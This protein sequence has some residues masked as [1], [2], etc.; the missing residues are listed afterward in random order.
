MLEGA[1]TLLS[2][3]YIVIYQGACAILILNLE[4][5]LGLGKINLSLATSVDLLEPCRLA[6]TQ[7]CG[8]FLRE[9]YR[10]KVLFARLPW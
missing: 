9:K 6:G 8:H 5:I 10:S 2:P 7:S 1:E 3:V 4:F